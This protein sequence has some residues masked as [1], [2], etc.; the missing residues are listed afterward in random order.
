LSLVI[1]L[2]MAWHLIMQRRRFVSAVGLVYF[3]VAPVSVLLTAT[4]GAF[5]AG[6]VALAIVPVTLRRRSIGVYAV[7]A[8]VVIGGAAALAIW[9]VPESNWDRVFTIHTEIA[10]GT[11]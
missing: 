11:M 1:G 9:F 7:S 10:E 3:V 2:P 5:L 8:L 4:R 6:I